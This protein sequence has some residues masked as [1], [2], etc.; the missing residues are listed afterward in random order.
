MEK[1]YNPLTEKEV[2]KFF[3]IVKEEYKSNYIDA[4]LSGA[5]D[6]RLLNP[7]DHTIAKC[8]LI[9]TANK[10]RPLSDLG[11]ETLRNLEKFI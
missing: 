6:Q 5:I 10:F 11:K 1:L 8:V 3:E 9:T 4:I 7:H 2:N